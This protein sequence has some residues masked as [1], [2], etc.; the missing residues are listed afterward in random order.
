[1][2]PE[3]TLL[4]GTLHTHSLC[5]ITL[6][7]LKQCLRVA[8][9]EVLF[10][11][12]D[13][14]LRTSGIYSIFLLSYGAEACGQNKLRK[15]RQEYRSKSSAYRKGRSVGSF[16]ARLNRSFL[17]IKHWQADATWCGR[18]LDCLPLLYGLT[19]YTNSAPWRL[20]L[21]RRRCCL[22]L[23][24]LFMLGRELATNEQRHTVD[25]YLNVLSL[26]GNATRQKQKMKRIQIQT[27]E[28]KKERMRI[29]KKCHIKNRA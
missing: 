17:V 18:A 5:A 27:K 6:R 15:Q 14:M 28:E 22:L 8:R 12:W 11:H 10:S 26:K 19:R 21:R 1:M 20:L 13:L 2:Q 25:C 4:N 9:L 29:K 3:A 23:H 24:H 16:L 7:L